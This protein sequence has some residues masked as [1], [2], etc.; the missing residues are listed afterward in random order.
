MLP[1]SAHGTI[2]QCVSF[3]SDISPSEQRTNVAMRSAASSLLGPSCKIMLDDN[4]CF[5]RATP[6]ATPWPDHQHHSHSAS[7]KY[8]HIPTSWLK[9][10]SLL[11]SSLTLH[12]IICSS[13]TFRIRNKGFL[14]DSSIQLT[15][16]TKELSQGKQLIHAHISYMH[17]IPLLSMDRWLHTIEVICL[18]AVQSQCAKPR[19]SFSFVDQTTSQP[20]L[21]TTIE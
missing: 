10:P 4:P 1:R 17:R 8:L 5:D 9:F 11:A 2:D 16:P 19:I 12:S 20:P 7:N 6:M 15:N 13:Q 21:H 14:S 18:V 3:A